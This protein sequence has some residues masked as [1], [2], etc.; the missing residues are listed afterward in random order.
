MGVF[1]VQGVLI[2]IVGTLAGVVIGVLIALNV[3]TLVPL[4]ERLVGFNFLPADVYYISELPSR[5]D[6]TDVIRIS[7]LSFVLSLLSTLYPAW[8]AARMEPAEALRYE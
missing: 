8:R 4:I 6:V 1:I 3:E 5:L 2:G 7:V